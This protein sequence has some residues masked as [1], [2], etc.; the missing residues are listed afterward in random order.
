MKAPVSAQELYDHLSSL[1][2]DEEFVM[3]AVRSNFPAFRSQS[4]SAAKPKRNLDKDMFIRSPRKESAANPDP[5]IIHSKPMCRTEGWYDSEV[6]DQ[7]TKK[8]FSQGSAQLLE[9]LHREHPAIMRHL[10]ARGNN[11]A[12]PKIGMPHA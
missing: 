11:V 5:K 12:M 4:K 2:D 1:I 7:L 8:G 10:K 9:A 3:R 6:T